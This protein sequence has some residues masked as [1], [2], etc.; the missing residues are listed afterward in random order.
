MIHYF[1]PGHET[2][3]LHASKHYHP[4]A[5]VAK[6][7]AD[8]AFLPAW[9]ASDG[10]CVFVETALPDDFIPFNNPVKT[11]V[12]NDF[13]TKPNQFSG[14]KISLWGISPA[15][16]HLFE[17]LNAERKLSLQIPEWNENF[18]FLGS[19]WASQKI[20]S[21]LMDTIPAIEKQILPRFFS[22]INEIEKQTIENREQQLVKSPYS[23][24]GRG[25]LWLPPG[26]LRQSEK[27][28]LKGMLKKQSCVSLENALDKRLDF[29]MHFEIKTSGETVF[30]G[31]SVFQTSAKGAYEKSRLAG[32]VVLK[33]QIASFINTDLLIHVRLALTEIIHEMY[34]PHYTG[35]IGVDMLVYSFG[36]RYKLHPCVEVNMRK[37]MGYLAICLFEKYLHPDSQGAFFT[38]YNPNPSTTVQKHKA[39]QKQYPL[40]TDSKNLIRS[41]YLNLCPVT[42]AT[43]FHA[44]ILVER[45]IDFV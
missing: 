14:S 29:S 8:L 41:G 42:D 34:A 38:E 30:A 15:S 11:V 25:L 36:G 32:Q 17:K 35:N 24:S 28:I 37:S 12:P 1:N 4:P 45:P 9:Y 33:E 20:L 7:Q 26:K 39:Q 5:H 23:S 27:Q 31:Y 43:N 44:Y 13:I 21:R 6:M 3:V 19:R 10:D 18:R 2:A 40:I 16:V 22:D